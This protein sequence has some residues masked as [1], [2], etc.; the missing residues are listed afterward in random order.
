MPATM[1]IPLSQRRD[2]EGN[3]DMN[4]IL[5]TN[6]PANRL[7]GDNSTLV[8]TLTAHAEKY[9]RCFGTKWDGQKSFKSLATLERRIAKA[10]IRGLYSIV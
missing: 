1:M 8:V 7:D 9:E 10:D 2:D 4:R 5:K 3:D 6:D